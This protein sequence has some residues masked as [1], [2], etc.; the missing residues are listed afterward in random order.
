MITAVVARKGGVGKT[1]TS[2][3]LTDALSAAGKSVLVVDF[4]PQGNCALGMGHE[5]SDEAFLFVVM[6]KFAPLVSRSGIDRGAG[7]VSGTISLL[8]GND[9]L[10]LAE[11][12]TQTR[13]IGQLVENLQ[14]LE[15]FGYDHIIIDTHAGTALSLAAAKAADVIIIPTQLE[16]LSVDGVAQ[17]ML[18]LDMAQATGQRFILPTMV[19]PA[20][21]AAREGLEFLE[22]EFP[23]QVLEGIP[24]R[25]A[26]SKAQGRGLLPSE[27]GQRRE[28]KDV[29]AAYAVVAAVLMAI[30]GED[31]EDEVDGDGL[32]Y[33]PADTDELDGDKE[34][35]GDE[36]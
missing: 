25:V 36:E 1:S 21:Q 2:I 22:G 26:V 8:A 20:L 5:P 35:E 3:G 6:G 19:N 29:I 17:Q 14:A 23:G 7:E 18:A 9:R 24:D 4:D 16:A 28:V 33:G 27:W 31:G 15:A 30:R 11:A 13:G 12:D 32:G 34:V 10:R